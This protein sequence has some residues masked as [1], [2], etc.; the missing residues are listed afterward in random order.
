MRG[1]AASAECTGRQPPAARVPPARTLLPAAR[2]QL[3]AAR[4][5][6]PA[7]RVP[8]ASR[9]QQGGVAGLLLILLGL[10][11]VLAWLALLDTTTWERADLAF[12][13]QTEVASLDPAV[14]SGSAEGR[15]I[16]ALFEGLTRMDPAD[17]D[18]LPALARSWQVS[19]DGLTWTFQL[20]E[21]ARW[22]DGSP[23]TA[24]DLRWSWTRLLHP[25]TGARYAYLLWAVEGAR[26]Y[27]AGPADA[28]LDD[29]PLGLEAPDPRRFVVRLER[30]APLLPRLASY[31][32]LAPVPR[33][34]VEAHGGAWAR[35]GTIVGN[36]PFLLAERRLR[37][38]VRLVRSPTYWGRDEVAL[39]TIDA[40]AA[41]G[42]TTQLNLYLTG[43]V[44]WMMKPPPSLY[45]ELLDRPD[46]RV[47]PQ[48]GTTFLR[49]NVR[50]PPLD[51]VRVRRALG[52][53]LDRRALAEQVMRGGER[54]VDTLVPPGLPGYD[55]PNGFGGPDPE[56]ARQLLA[57]AGY[58]GGQGLRPLE[59]LYPHNAATRD[60]CAAVAAGWRREL[61]LEVRLV[62]QAFEVYLDSTVQGLYDVSWGT[63]I[64]DY[65]DPSTF[66]E[67]F[68][69]GSGN[70]RTGWADPRY[71]ALVEQAAGQA[72]A[73][74][75]GHLL[76]QAEALLLE[77][78]PL[79]PVYQRVNI[80]LVSPRVQGF[81]D[82]LLDVHPLRD[83]S[84]T[85]PP[86]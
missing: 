21:D 38:R 20:R 82:N 77:A 5:L 9:R 74:A 76:T 29:A 68:L 84:V 41:D 48:L 35:P 51:D 27:S 81:H 30:P 85:G 4:T 44:D 50:R 2:A 36:G 42:L 39:E 14:G 19:G 6:L 73:D 26:A 54:P 7:A 69:S 22:S 78:A 49:F 31:H 11:P 67:A 15:L 32:A 28:P 65:L 3:P 56:R 47:G 46:A 59:L 13:N 61:G 25:A 37:D 12:C 52:L 83:L 66:L 86:P 72:D 75:R 34:V 23:V 17:T 43:V 64:G 1:A 70:N 24:E 63:W 58:P 16:A 8:P 80:H 79:A 33:R 10:I 53:T 18:P 45:G 57:K 55:G 62:N 40:Y 60:F 71:D